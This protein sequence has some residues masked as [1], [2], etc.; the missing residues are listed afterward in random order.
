MIRSKKG[1]GEE[2][3][4]IIFL[5]L[6]LLAVVIVIV[7]Y[8]S[9]DIIDYFRNLPGY[10]YSINDTIITDRDPN[11]PN[12]CPIKVGFVGNYPGLVLGVGSFSYITFCLDGNEIGNPC[13][14][15]IKYDA[16]L[17]EGDRFNAKLY[18][19]RNAWK[20]QK[21]ALVGEIKSTVITMDKTFLGGTGESYEKSQS[22][23][24]SIR[25]ISALEIF[26]RLEKAFT[27]NG[28]W[29]CRKSPIS[30]E[31]IFADLKLAKGQK[32]QYYYDLKDFYLR[33]ND[34]DT[35][36][37]NWYLDSGKSQEGG[38]IYFNG[39]VYDKDGI[40]IDNVKPDIDSQLKVSEQDISKYSSEASVQKIQQA[41]A[42]KSNWIKLKAE[43]PNKNNVLGVNTGGDAFVRVRYQID[44]TSKKVYVQF[45]DDDT[46]PDPNDESPWIRMDYWN[47][48]QTFVG[49]GATV[50]AYY[51]NQ[52]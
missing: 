52:N 23:L 48:Y 33:K 41:K 2:T 18:I 43:I 28:N 15:Q 24:P 44:P 34:P 4:K 6:A 51:W 5:V 12:S 29:I 32:S 30:R 45:S 26:A 11:S 17:F 49:A 22:Y 20:L 16:L 9:S 27:Y 31:L 42:G 50:W 47:Q 25:G 46:W 10:D 8:Y 3:Q 21:N 1:A 36:Y 40:K 38:R 39:D 13:R 35:T 19:D 37:I 14:Q 7:F